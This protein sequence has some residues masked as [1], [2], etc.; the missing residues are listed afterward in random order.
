M[1]SFSSDCFSFCLANANGLPASCGCEQD[2][3]FLSLGTEQS[4][5]FPKPKTMSHSQETSR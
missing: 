2:F 5:L 1:V 4:T 3:F